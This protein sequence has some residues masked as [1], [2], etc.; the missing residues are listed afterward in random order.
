MEKI[1]TLVN[2][3]EKLSAEFMNEANTNLG[4]NKAA[5]RRARKITLTLTKMFKDYR[6]WTVEAENA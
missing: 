3:I 6:A 1:Q 4:G 5:G 2:E